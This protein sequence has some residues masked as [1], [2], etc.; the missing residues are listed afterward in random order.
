MKIASLLCVMSRTIEC[1]VVWGDAYERREKNSGMFD[2]LAWLLQ[3][4]Y[5][6]QLFECD[7]FQFSGNLLNIRAG[8]VSIDVFFADK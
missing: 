4:C 7:S 2:P 1:V 3:Y 5:G 8:K 6:K